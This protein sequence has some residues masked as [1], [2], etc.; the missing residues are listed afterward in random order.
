MNSDS[1]QNKAEHSAALL[2]CLEELL[3]HH[4]RLAV[5]IREYHDSLLNILWK[6]EKFLEEEDSQTPAGEIGSRQ[7]AIGRYL[8]NQID[9][10]ETDSPDGGR[11]ANEER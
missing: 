6:V 10:I 9:S 5:I 11:S 7:V 2:A 4:D 3:E 1:F 8:I